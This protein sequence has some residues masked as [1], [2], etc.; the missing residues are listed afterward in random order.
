VITER[1]ATS[2]RIHLSS[3]KKIIEIQ[4][5]IQNA[6]HFPSISISPT[7]A[8]SPQVSN[9]VEI[10]NRIDF[11]DQ[12][13]SNPKKDSHISFQIL[14]FFLSFLLVTVLFAIKIF[15]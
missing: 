8:V 9:K 2:S 13:G 1:T 11:S 5:Q 7:I 14:A 6:H 4:S 10:I 15:K 12:K 3:L